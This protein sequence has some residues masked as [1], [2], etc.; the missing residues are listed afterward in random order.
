MRTDVLEGSRRS[1]TV[2]A[3]AKYDGPSQQEE[4][5]GGLVCSQLPDKDLDKVRQML[6]NVNH[7]LNVH[8][9]FAFYLSDTSKPYPLFLSL[10]ERMKKKKGINFNS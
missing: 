7:V 10:S 4:K 6:I 8:V 3:E 2:L 9:Q 5:F 1:R